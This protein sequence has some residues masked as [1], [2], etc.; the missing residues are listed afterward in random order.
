MDSVI[1][2]NDPNSYVPLLAAAMFGAVTMAVL[3]MV[4]SNSSITQKSVTSPSVSKDMD[5]IKKSVSSKKASDGDDQVSKFAGSKA[6]ALMK[7]WLDSKQTT[8]D[9][10]KFF[11][12]VFNILAKEIE[13]D[14]IANFES[15]KDAVQWV[16]KLMK[17]SVP[18]GKMNRG[19]TVVHTTRTCAQGRSLTPKELYDAAVLGWCVEWLQA[20]F[21]VADDVMDSS[22]TRRGKDCWYRLDGVGNC[23]I[24]D[25]F[26]LESHIYR[27]LRKHFKNSKS[28]DGSNK[29]MK[30]IDLFHEVTYQ[31]ELGQ[32]LDLTTQPLPP[33]IPDLKKF[34]LKRHAEIVKYKTAF[35]SFYLPVALG[36]T[37]GNIEDESAFE[38]A[39]EICL[40]MGEYFQV[41]DDYLDCYGSPEVIGKIGTDIK[42]CKCS[43]L[44]VNAK[45][46]CTRSQKRILEEHYGKGDNEGSEKA[47]KKLYNELQLE[48]DFEGYEESS[49]RTIV[50]LIEQVDENVMPKEI[51]NQLLK[52]IYKR[53]L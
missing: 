41:Q 40:V 5:K 24:N 10:R 37:L 20:F 30:I 11:S 27:C 42:D 12:K 17:H 38:Q 21:L 50:D 29:Y 52:K 25:S 9:D 31:T 22:L 45:N 3:Q 53:K 49:Y 13:E 34:T 39:L 51:F 35:Y 4:I 6:E 36:L 33:A 14:M 19:L 16:K 23:A 28:D 1:D 8:K 44:V 32:L 15:P 26:I 47:I 7:D 2:F 18:G 43:W 48:N 46:K